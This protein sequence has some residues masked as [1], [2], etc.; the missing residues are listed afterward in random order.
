MCTTLCGYPSIYSAPAASGTVQ[1][2]TVE[3]EAAGLVVTPFKK[4]GGFSEPIVPGRVMGI[5]AGRQGDPK[6]AGGRAWACSL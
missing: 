5:A 6:P 2:Y 3:V 1:R 4:R